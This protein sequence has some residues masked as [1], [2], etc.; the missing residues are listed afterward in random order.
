M[1]LT[2]K[3]GWWKK[4]QSNIKKDTF[5]WKEQKRKVYR[6]FKSNYYEMKKKKVGEKRKE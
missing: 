3:Y 6:I 1:V 2:E 4:K 5:G